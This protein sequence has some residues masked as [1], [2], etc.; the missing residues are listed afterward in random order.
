MKLLRPILVFFLLAIASVSSAFSQA[1]SGSLLGTVTDSSGG[2]VPN[3]K[4]T[5][6]ETQTGVSRTTNT[7]ESGNYTFSD[8]PPGKYT[9]AAEQKGFKRAARAGVDVNVNSTERVDLML[10]PGEITETVNVTADV[11]ILKTERA[12]TGRQIETVQLHELPLGGGHNFQSLSV[13][14]PGAALPESQHSAFFNPQVSLATRFN[15]QSRLSDN[16]QLEGVDDNERTG[17]LQVLIPP[18]E[19]IQT[20]DVSTSNFEAELGRATGAV[21]NVVLKSGTNQYRGEV[22][23]FNRVSALAARN[24]Y[25]AA[26]SH[27]TYNYFGGLFGG[28]IRKNRTFFFGDYLRIEDHSAN[29]DRLTVPLADMR[30]GNLNV[31]APGKTPTVIYDPATGD[32]TTGLGRQAFAGNIIPANRINPISAKILSLIPLPNLINP[33]NPFAQNLFVNSPFYRNTDQFDVKVDHMQTDRDRLSVRYSFSRPVTFDSSVYG[34][35]GGPRGVSGSGFEG[36]GIQNTHSGAI[37]YNHIFSPTLITEVRAGVNRYRN[38]AQQ[39]GYGQNTADQLGIPGINGIPWTSGPPQI[40]LDNFGDPFIGFSASLPWIRAET[41]ILLTNSWTKTHGNHTIKWG[42]EMRRVRDDLLQTQTVNPRGRYQFSTAQTS[43]KVDPTSFTNSFAAF[44]LDVPSAAGRDFPEIFPAYRAW[45]FFG[46]VQDKWVVTPKLTVDIGLRWEFYPPAKPAHTA[47]FSQFNPGN[48]TL[49]IAGVG[50]N[51]LDLGLHS[52]WHD[53]GPRLGIAY[54]VND[55]TVVRTGFGM[56]YSPFPDNTYAYNYPVKQ[57][58]VFSQPSTCSTCGVLL[59]DGSPATFQSGFPP[60]AAVVIPSNGIISRP[61]PNQTYFYINPLFREPYV[62]AWNFAIQRTLPRNFAWE[63]AYVGNHGVDQPAVYNLNASLTLGANQAGQPLFAA[64]GQKA[65]VEDRYVG[66]SSM[67][68]GL[69]TKL[70]RRFSNG[71]AMTTSY[72]FSKAMGM[73]SEDAGLDF[74]INP[75]RNWRRLDFDR[76]HTFAQSYVYELPFGRG[77]RLLNSGAGSWI[78]G[79][80]QVNGILTIFSGRPI[81]FSGNSSIL[82]APGNNN[83]LNWFGPGPIPTPKGNGLT[84]LWFTP[85]ICNFDPTKGSLVVSQCF[86]Q[87]GAENG[88]KPEFGNLGRNPMTGPGGWNLDASLFRSFEFSDRYKLQFRGEAFSVVNTPQWGNPSTDI[89][90]SNFGKITG[91][92][93]ARSIQLSVKL[94][95]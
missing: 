58:N 31:A 82:G 22:Y 1:V 15:G 43:N 89:N 29:N 40:A 52:N 21:T 81:N 57:N 42:G 38:D 71:F 87:P 54:R 51:P 6:T 79:G 63:V 9:V 59:P 45:Q 26:R 46:F 35:F 77:K 44:L 32:P 47:G 33:A 67:Y 27:F 4:V 37:N 61:D 62:E 90:S 14:V 85:T 74:Y 50:G 30:T 28:P 73:Q 36:T 68:H 76:T 8:L 93:G 39:V 84:G 75:R 18:Q 65:S 20:V 16:L 83:T 91:A 34:I 17:L 53:F 23:E 56:S 11:P 48:D 49:E 3:A 94:M 13:L 2:A 24:F 92:G 25:D 88:G 55:K 66:Y 60:F 78:L 70:D 7:N 95:F 12:D 86:A 64:Y 80:W 41:N 5:I 69:Q 19:A 10:T 72:T